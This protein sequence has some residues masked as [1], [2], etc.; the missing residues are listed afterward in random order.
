MNIRYWYS[1]NAGLWCEYTD[2]NDYYVIN[3]EW[4]GTRNGDEFTVNYTGKVIVIT[5][6]VIVTRA[7]L[8]GKLLV[9]GDE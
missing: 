9:R 4:D 7:E 5:D 2:S 6:W 3:G 8:V 1:E